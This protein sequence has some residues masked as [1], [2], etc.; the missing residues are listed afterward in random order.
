MQQQR[1]HFAKM[2]R[3]R[4]K[5]AED[6]RN[7][8]DRQTSGSLPSAPVPKSDP[9]TLKDYKAIASFVMMSATIGGFTFLLVVLWKGITGEF[10]PSNP[11]IAGILQ[12]GVWAV[13]IGGV[14]LGITFIDIFKKIAKFILILAALFFGAA[15]VY[16]LY[17][18]MTGAG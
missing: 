4:I 18:G 2:E 5:R 7:H 15:M 13:G 8:R 11:I 9:L 10:H 14:S 6:D 1:D 3:D 17:Q 12:H 16:A